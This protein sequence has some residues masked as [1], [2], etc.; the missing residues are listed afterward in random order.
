MSERGRKLDEIARRTKAL[1]ERNRDEIAAMKNGEIAEPDD[2]NDEEEIDDDPRAE[3]D[4]IRQDK[5]HP[6]NDPKAT[7]AEHQQAVDYVNKLIAR[8]VRS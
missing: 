4:A 6:F 8:T 5:T 7:A 1:L 2:Y 3:L